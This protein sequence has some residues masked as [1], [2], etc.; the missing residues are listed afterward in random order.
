MT[1]KHHLLCI[2]VD[3]SFDLGQPTHSEYHVVGLSIG[4]YHP[5][6]DD[7][8]AKLNWYFLDFPKWDA[9]L[10]TGDNQGR[11]RKFINFSSKMIQKVL[12]NDADSCSCVND[13]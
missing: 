4:H 5:D 9:S 1:N 6:G 3:L 7:F 2:R 8:I 11:V 12:C 10:S 13:H